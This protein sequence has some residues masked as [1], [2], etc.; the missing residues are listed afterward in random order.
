M[1]DTGILSIMVGHIL[2]PAYSKFFNPDLKDEDIMP[3][4]LSGEILGGLLRKK[5][6]FNGVIVTDAT[7]M[8]GFTAVMKRSEAI[9]A[10]IMAGCDMILFNKDIREDYSFIRQAL[11]D[12]RLTTERFFP[13]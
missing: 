6:G 7:P 9:P 1:V 3:A 5:L 2:Q 12:G 4:T 10:C 11:L 13:A 8:L